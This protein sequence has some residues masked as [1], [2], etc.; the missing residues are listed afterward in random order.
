[1]VVGARGMVGS[2]VVRK[3]KTLAFANVI[4]ISRHDCDLLHQRETFEILLRCRPDVVIMCAAK[5]GGI[6]AN[7]EFRKDFI[8]E[9]LQMQINVIE[10]AFRASVDKL[11]FLGSSC[12]YPKNIEK[13]ITEE[14]LLSGPLEYTNQ[15]YAVAKIAGIE[16][17]DAYNTQ[18]GVDYRSIMPCNLYG[19]GDNYDLQT[20]HVIPA[21]IRKFSE[22]KKQRAKQVT[23][24][25]S[26]TP[27]REFLHVDDLAD[28]LIQIQST[29]TADFRKVIGPT[30]CH[31]NVGSG[32][33]LAITDLAE[34]ISQLVGFHGNIVFDPSKPDGT[35]R[36]VLDISRIRKL[37]W[38]QKIDLLEGLET[39]ICSFNKA[40][41]A[42]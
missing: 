25:G 17:C 31:I 18:Y 40:Q 19:P 28:A 6:H 7:N 38:T 41:R 27:R 36:K 42:S 9:N 32:E 34:Q 24:W 14:A 12:I 13:P 15:P 1:M 33:D 23:L 20:S 37:G 4:P 8:Y 29:S 16:M 3:L 39:T 2:A 22:A 35:M 10:G 21:L 11:I 5:V 30:G 26:G